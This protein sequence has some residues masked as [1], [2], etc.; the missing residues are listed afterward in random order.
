MKSYDLYFFYDKSSH[1]DFLIFFNLI[2]K[3][4]FFDFSVVSCI[5]LEERDFY[6]ESIKLKI[7]ESETI[8]CSVYNQFETWEHNTC[9]YSLSYRP[10]KKKINAI[11]FSIRFTSEQ[12]FFES[13]INELINIKGFIYGNIHDT[14][15]AIIESQS[16]FQYFEVTPEVLKRSII[17]KD[18]QGNILIDISKNYGRGFWLKEFYLIAGAKMWFGPSCYSIFDKEALHKYGETIS[19]VNGEEIIH[20][21]L[22]DILSS[23]SL[24]ENRLKQ[25]WFWDTFNL[26]KLEKLSKENSSGAGEFIFEIT[27]E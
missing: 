20:I 27:L 4:R 21:K 17:N 16:K 11:Q 6:S 5:E 24:P 19:N 10:N 3:Y 18:N 23:P 25:K 14:Y 1:F 12:M 26:D 7:I 15:D 2:E 9:G 22:F 8:D 13:I